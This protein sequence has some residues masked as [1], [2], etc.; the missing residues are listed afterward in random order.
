MRKCRR[1]SDVEQLLP[2]GI[3]DCLHA[4][5]KVKFIE[6]VADVILDCVLGDEQIGP[7]IAIVLA[8]RHQLQDFQLSLG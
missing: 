1:L 3:D 6:D 8:P 4:G 5:V 2:H 7:D